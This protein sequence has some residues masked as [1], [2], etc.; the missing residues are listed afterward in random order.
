MITPIVVTGRNK[1]TSAPRKAASVPA[2]M[3]TNPAMAIGRRV[4][5][6]TISVLE[7]PFCSAFT[8]ALAIL[9][10]N[11][12]FS[13]QDRQ[14]LSRPDVSLAQFGQYIINSSDRTAF[15]SVRRE[16][17]PTQ[18][19]ISRSR[20]DSGTI[21]HRIDRAAGWS[22]ELKQFR[23]Q[24]LAFSFHRQQQ[25]EAW[26]PN[27]LAVCIGRIQHIAVPKAV[28]RL[29]ALLKQELHN[30]KR[31]LVPTEIKTEVAIVFNLGKDTQTNQADVLEAATGQRASNNFSSFRSF[32][33]F[34]SF[35]GLRSFRGLLQ[36][37]SPHGDDNEHK[38]RQGDE[39]TRESQRHF[40]DSKSD[41]QVVSQYT[42]I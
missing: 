22:S 40:T 7:E 10:M 37:R 6:G 42:K 27:S 17:Y 5:S 1:N 8:S 38:Q 4:V 34:R 39:Q 26:T 24:S 41:P 33:S 13:P 31:N 28:V 16:V 20:T 30:P 14:N 11:S 19:V 3:T 23:V 25:A 2:I 9:E 29:V 12:S 15:D 21:T 36:G 18:R 32:R 35:P